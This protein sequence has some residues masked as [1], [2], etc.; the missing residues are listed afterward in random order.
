MQMYFCYR[1]KNFGKRLTVMRTL[2]SISS[3]E[4]GFLETML[5]YVN[6]FASSTHNVSHVALLCGLP[7]YLD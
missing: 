5:L 3:S 6:L 1:V 2:I 4:N 7:T